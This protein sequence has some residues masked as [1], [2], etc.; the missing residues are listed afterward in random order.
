MQGMRGANRV[1]V[2]SC[3]PNRVK[4]FFTL[5]GRH[6]SGATLSFLSPAWMNF[7]IDPQ[8]RNAL[9]I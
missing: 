3:V 5:P 6:A 9:A 7:E 8:G 1:F 2:V 4:N